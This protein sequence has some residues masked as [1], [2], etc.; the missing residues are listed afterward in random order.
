M[1]PPRFSLWI[2]LL[3]VFFAILLISPDSD[4]GGTDVELQN[5]SPTH[6]TGEISQSTGDT[7]VSGDKNR[8]YALGL[9]DVD[10]NDCYRS[11]QIAVIFQ[12]SQLNYWCMAD[13]LDAKGLHAA[14]AVTRCKLDGYRKLFG[15]MDDCV[16][17][18]TMEVFIPPAP[19][20]EITDSDEDDDYHQQLEQA[21]A[22]LRIEFEATQAK[23]AEAKREAQRAARQPQ[24]VIQKEEFLDEEKR[25]KLEALKGGK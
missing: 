7:I 17:M 6:I 10:I 19:E 5:Y 21:V 9:G 23:A 24:T 20:P 11:Y 15:D 22:A 12:G 14:A 25:A 3:V 4:A 8:A 18:N 2:F 13:S 16:A 1:K